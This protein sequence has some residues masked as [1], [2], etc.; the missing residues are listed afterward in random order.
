MRNGTTE[1]SQSQLQRSQQDIPRLAD[2]LTAMDRR[3]HRSA[4]SERDCGRGLDSQQAWCCIGGQLTE[5]NEQNTQQ[6]P[7]FGRN[8][9]L[10][11][12]HS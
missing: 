11:R 8:N 7:G 3:P 9:A 2:R 1:R 12:E 10:Q 4:G 5:P 6:W